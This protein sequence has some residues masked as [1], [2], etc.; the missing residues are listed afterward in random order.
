MTKFLSKRLL[1]RMLINRYLLHATMLS[2]FLVVIQT[3]FWLYLKPTPEEYMQVIS[4]FTIVCLGWVPVATVI[5][6]LFVT[7]HK[8]F[9]ALLGK[10]LFRECAK[11]VAGSGIVSIFMVMFSYAYETLHDTL[12]IEL[13]K[14]FLLA[15][16]PFFSIAIL[17]IIFSFALLA[18]LLMIQF[19]D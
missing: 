9:S 8:E 2:I 5:M 14:W 4:D 16:T 15:I 6:V 11:V 3:I 17:M 12:S 1:K 13:Q 7:Q 19:E 10:N 18:N